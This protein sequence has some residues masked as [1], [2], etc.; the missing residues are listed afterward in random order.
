MTDLAVEALLD[1]DHELKVETAK[2]AAAEL[3]TRDRVEAD[4]DSLF[5][6]EDWRRC[7][8]RGVQGL[9]VPE[10]YGGQGRD[11]LTASLVL[12]GL[13]YGCRDNGLSYAVAS[14]IVSTQVAL[15][16]FG[17]EDQKAEWLPGLCDGTSRAAFAMTELESGSDAFAM[18]SRARRTASGYELSGYKAFITL[19]PRCDLILAFASTD[20]DAGKWGISAF[21]FPADTQGVTLHP[22]REKMGLRTT[23]FGDIELA[24]V[25][26]PESARLGPEGAGASIFTS[27]MD[28]ER[29]LV[30]ATQVGAMERTLEA[31]VEFARSRTQSG[32]PIGEFQGVSHRIAE[33]K[34]RHETAR[35]FLY[36]TALLLDRG[37][38]S[39][40]AAAMTKL[41]ASEAAVA[42]AMD[43][44]TIFG[45]RGYVSQFEV[46]RELRDALG[47]LSYSGTS[48]I[49]RNVIARLLGVG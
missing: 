14:Q 41:V 3:A 20:P 32:R 31:V 26:V 7:A 47:G 34:V 35:L 27:A 48:E 4:R 22:N 6:E 40:I 19:A 36:K 10:A 28:T 12:E 15:E 25:A 43:A 39:S 21:V 42:S 46:E 8:E 45:A 38:P 11:H 30:F 23:P 33:M 2:W 5:S 1:P 17:T 37:R 44:S 24:D 9:I 49:Q 18:T 29:A 16:T 13:G